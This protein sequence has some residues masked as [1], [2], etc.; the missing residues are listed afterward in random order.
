MCL[1]TLF[2]LACS[3]AEDEM[4]ADAAPIGP[5]APGAPCTGALYDTCTSDTQCASDNCQI[6]SAAT[7][8]VCSQTC[9]AQTPC[10][11]QGGLPA[12]CT[13]AGVCRPMHS[14]GC[15]PN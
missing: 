13:T 11:P 15:D 6:F 1:V 12:M 2:A 4:P 8:H 14:S 5:D 10:P 3:G 7:L 9:N